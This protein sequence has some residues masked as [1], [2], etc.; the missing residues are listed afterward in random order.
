VKEKIIEIRAL[1]GPVG[2][3]WRT[4]T[5]SQMKGLEPGTAIAITRDADAGRGQSTLYTVY[6]PPRR[7]D[8]SPVAYYRRTECVDDRFTHRHKGRYYCNPAHCSRSWRSKTE[9]D[10][11][12]EM[13]YGI[14]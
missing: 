11:H 2:N 1:I 6:R 13:A 7:R 3:G 8:E 9:R 10:K 4:I 12:L 5:K 14:L